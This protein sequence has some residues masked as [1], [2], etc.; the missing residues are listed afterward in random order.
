MK[1]IPYETPAAEL[2]VV[3]YEGNFCATG[4]GRY[5]DNNHTEYIDGDGEIDTL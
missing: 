1:M 3:Q 2:L 4:D 5:N